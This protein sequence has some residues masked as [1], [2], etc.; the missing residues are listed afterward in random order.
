MLWQLEISGRA[1]SAMYD[2]SLR[3]RLAGS[4]AVIN[5]QQV[6]TTDTRISSP[7]ENIVSAAQPDVVVVPPS[8]DT[9]T[10][11]ALCWA[12]KR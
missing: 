6:T 1:A 4:F 5:D 8:V 10:K 7:V 12:F 2:S 9:T 11:S 3:S